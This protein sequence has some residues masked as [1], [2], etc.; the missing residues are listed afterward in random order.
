MSGDSPELQIGRDKIESQYE[1]DLQDEA[2]VTAPLKPKKTKIRVV[3]SEDHPHVRSKIRSLLSTV[4]DI[5]IVGEASN[6]YEAVQLTEETAPDVLLLDIEMPNMNGLLVAKVL[7]ANQSDVKVL[8]LSAYN[9]RVWIENVLS[10]GVVGY[11]LKDDA[12]TLLIRAIRGVAEGQT[13]WFSPSVQPVM[14]STSP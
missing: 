14:G 4:P 12:P 11:L 8:V 1:L 7:K 5:C 10:H 6:G 13:G 3:I 9:D 2:T